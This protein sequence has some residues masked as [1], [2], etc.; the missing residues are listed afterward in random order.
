MSDSMSLLLLTLRNLR[1]PWPSDWPGL[2]VVARACLARLG[3]HPD[4]PDLGCRVSCLLEL[5]RLVEEDGA[6]RARA[7]A[8]LAYHNRL[9][10]ADTLVAL[11]LLIRVQSAIE[12]RAAATVPLL[13]IEALIAMVAHDYLHD[14]TV[15]S[16]LGEIEA[17]S[18]AAIEPPLV[19]LGLPAD[20]RQRVL[21]WIM[22]TDPAVVADHHRWIRQRP[23]SVD[24]P[25]CLQAMINEADILVSALPDFERAQTESLVRERRQSGADA[26]D[27]LLTAQA[28]RHFLEQ[29]AIF[30]SDA[31]RRLGLD[32]LRSSQLR[33]LAAPR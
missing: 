14:G 3:V 18:C 22:A 2:P 8:E 26:S 7:G 20:S 17:R 5:A 16:R 28:R 32:R 9:H 29:V 12:S 19:R 31:S 15:N 27:S 13:W 33:A 1:R 25:L 23:F 6:R 4:G 21:G 11:T 24:D 30:S 10:I